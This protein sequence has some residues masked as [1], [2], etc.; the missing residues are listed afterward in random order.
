MK[1]GLVEIFQIIKCK[2]KDFKHHHNTKQNVTHMQYKPV[3]T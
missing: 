1:M 2:R 3:N